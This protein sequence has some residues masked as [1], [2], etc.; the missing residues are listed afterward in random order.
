MSEWTYLKSPEDRDVESKMIDCF[1]VR[2]RIYFLL[3]K[4]IFLVSRDF[5]EVS[6][7]Y[8][9]VEF[10]V[11]RIPGLWRIFRRAIFYPRS[12]VASRGR[13]LL[14]PRRYNLFWLLWAMDLAGDIKQGG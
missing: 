1:E 5:I 3:A 14:Y 13:G 12:V 2:P 6:D 7:G 10:I 11:K 9:L 4:L 8:L